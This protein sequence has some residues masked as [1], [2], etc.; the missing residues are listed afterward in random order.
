MFEHDGEKLRCIV[1]DGGYVA[2]RRSKLLNQIAK[3]F[4]GPEYGDVVEGAVER[5]G[6][7]KVTDLHIIAR[8]ALNGELLARIECSGCTKVHHLKGQ[9]AA[10]AALNEKE[11]S[12]V[13]GVQQLDETETLKRSGVF[14][15][16]EVL[17]VKTLPPIDTYAE[18][19][20][21]Y[22]KKPRVKLSFI[23]KKFVDMEG[24][25]MSHRYVVENRALSF[26]SLD[27]TYL[28][29]R[30]NHVYNRRA[31]WI[32]DGRKVHFSVRSICTYGGP[33]CI[34]PDN[35]SIIRSGRVESFC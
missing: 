22:H 25:Y 7:I 16:S 9:I 21:V 34:N 33:G 6:W 35:G 18:M 11:F 1:P 4:C 28:G 32:M 5:D 20:N 29:M 27:G 12:L 17:V 2:F 14:P 13:A 24:E 8:S 26:C 15:G 30:V 10:S 3:E 23:V 19:L 31:Q